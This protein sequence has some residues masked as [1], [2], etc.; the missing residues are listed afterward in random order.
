MIWR[1]SLTT[2]HHSLREEN[3]YGQNMHFIFNEK[4]NNKRDQTSK[5][6]T[7]NPHHA[8][9]HL[10]AN[11]PEGSPPHTNTFG[12]GAVQEEKWTRGLG[13]CSNGGR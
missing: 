4:V 9:P 1:N 3:F 11:V 2:V 13:E 6:R 7:N 12:F 8:Y 10:H 5:G